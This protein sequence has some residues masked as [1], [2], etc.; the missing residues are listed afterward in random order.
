MKQTYSKPLSC[1]PDL[2]IAIVSST[3]SNWY[4]FYFKLN[5]HNFKRMKYVMYRSE[6]VALGFHSCWMGLSW[7]GRIPFPT[8]C[9]VPNLYSCH[10]DS[11]QILSSLWKSIFLLFLCLCV[12]QAPLC[13]Q[14]QLC[15]SRGN[16]CACAAKPQALGA[17]YHLLPASSLYLQS[18]RLGD[19]SSVTPK[20]VVFL[21][22]AATV[23]WLD[24]TLL[25]PTITFCL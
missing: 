20:T 24:P 13:L 18:P 4:H 22:H 8:F 14:R 23:R 16:Y 10:N 21:P 25:H 9:S 12:E 17:R 11:H 2:F 5:L 15:V 19:L 7:Y 1:E 3:S 6:A